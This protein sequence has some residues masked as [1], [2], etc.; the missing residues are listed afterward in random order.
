MIGLVHDGRWKIFNFISFGFFIY[1]DVVYFSLPCAQNIIWLLNWE[2]Y[3][4][5]AEWI[6]FNAFKYINKKSTI[7]WGKTTQT[8]E[9]G[10]NARKIIGIRSNMKDIVKKNDQVIHNIFSMWLPS[11]SSIVVSGWWWKRA[12]VW[13]LSCV[14]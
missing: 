7:F 9:S 4:R 3:A 12:L 13:C 14:L 11:V 1:S 2:I 10:K 6:Q 5:R 8:Q